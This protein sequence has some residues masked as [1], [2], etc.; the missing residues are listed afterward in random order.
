[1]KKAL[2]LGITIL[3][4]SGCG[5]TNINRE[6]LKGYDC[7]KIAFS[8]PQ[9]YMRFIEGNS[10]GCEMNKSIKD[11]PNARTLREIVKQYIG[12]KIF[13]AEDTDK[14]FVN[15]ENLDGVEDFSQKETG[16]IGLN[17]QI[18][19]EI[20]QY[21]IK[22]GVMTKKNEFSG[23]MTLSVHETGKS[24]IIYDNKMYDISNKEEITNKF[25]EKAQKKIFA[26]PNT[27]EGKF[28]LTIKSQIDS[29][30]EAYKYLLKELEKESASPST[31]NPVPQITEAPSV[32][33]K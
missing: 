31:E 23:P 11:D 15:Y 30:V 6:Y 1:M 24:Y 26:D 14:T 20:Q 29:E 12:T 28:K 8:C 4:L 22:D 25:T 9:Y 2:M 18:W 27:S 32:Q 19:A 21:S 5:S 7:S 10:C 13:K 17:Y 33:V 3:I 16:I